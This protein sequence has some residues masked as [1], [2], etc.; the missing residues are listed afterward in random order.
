MHTGRARLDKVL[1]NEQVDPEAL[2]ELLTDQTTASPT[3]LSTEELLSEPEKMTKR[4]FID[5]PVYGT[6]SST[7][8]L[9]DRNGEMTFVERQFDAGG[10]PIG[11]SSH[12]FKSR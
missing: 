3:R 2:L 12:K 10:N 6:R 7:V 11:T 5:S 8:L 1:K 9:V 4:I